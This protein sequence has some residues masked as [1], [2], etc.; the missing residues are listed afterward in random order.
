MSDHHS[1][2]GCDFR[3][4]ALI[5][6]A[7]MTPIKHLIAC[8]EASTVAAVRRIQ[9]RGLGQV[10]VGTRGICIRSRAVEEECWQEQDAE[11]VS[12]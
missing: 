5:L 3:I 2:K 7:L 1:L 11:F 9:G 8:V 10:Q 12:L 4:M 6:M